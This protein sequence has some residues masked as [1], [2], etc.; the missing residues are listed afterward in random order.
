MPAF[1]AVRVGFDPTKRKSLGTA[2]PTCY[3]GVMQNCYTFIDFV[4]DDFNGDWRCM[5]DSF[6]SYTR[7]V[8]DDFDGDYPSS[9][10]NQ[11]AAGW[12]AAT[13]DAADIRYEDSGPG[14]GL[15]G[16]SK[17]QIMRSK[18][19]KTAS[20]AREFTDLVEGREY[21]LSVWMT[22]RL[23]DLAIDSPSATS[24]LAFG[25]D[26]TG[27][28]LDH[29][30]GSIVWFPG[31]DE[32]CSGASCSTVWKQY[33]GGFTAT[34]TGVVSL[35]V[36]AVSCDAA[37]I[38][39][40]VDDFYITDLA[41][42]LWEAA[43]KSNGMFNSAKAR[44]LIGEGYRGDVAT[45][46]PTGPPTSTPTLTDTPIGGE[47]PTHTP[48][49]TPKSKSL[50]LYYVPG[51]VEETPTPTQQGGSAPSPTQTPTWI[52]ADR[53]F[54]IQR[55]FDKESGDWAH[56]NV[57]ISARVK[58]ATTADVGR[59]RLGW[60]IPTPYE[61]P[62]LGDAVWVTP[63]ITPAE[64]GWSKVIGRID[65]W[66]AENEALQ[67]TLYIGLDV[68]D[69]TAAVG[70][71]VDD[72][73]VFNDVP[74]N[75]ANYEI[76]NLG[77]MDHYNYLVADK[78]VKYK[79]DHSYEG[80]LLFNDE[81]GNGGGSRYY[82]RFY[83]S[84]QSG[85]VKLPS[86]ADSF[87]ADGTGEEWGE[88]SIIRE[89]MAVKKKNEKAYECLG[90]GEYLPPAHIPDPSPASFV[91]ESRFLP[92]FV[93]EM[94]NWTDGLMINNP[95]GIMPMHS[96]E[97]SDETD[98][99]KGASSR[100]IPVVTNGKYVHL[101][102][103]WSENAS[104]T[105]PSEIGLLSDFFE[106]AQFLTI[107]AKVDGATPRQMFMGVALL[108]SA[109][110]S[111]DESYWENHYQVCL[112]DAEEGGIVIDYKD[113]R[114]PDAIDPVKAVTATLTFNDE[115]VTDW[116]MVYPD[117]WPTPVEDQQHIG[118]KYTVTVPRYGCIVTRF[119]TRKKIQWR[120]EE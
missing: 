72:V 75:D 18:N 26:L 19:A 80:D 14:K 32:L 76:A 16:S 119:V 114:L 101:G 64:D 96:N 38:G 112:A 100:F 82:Q 22:A 45:S 120:A 51:A 20:I 107:D 37:G 106:D 9:P 89:Y 91:E 23:F 27:Q 103:A 97:W 52:P 109:A 95:S 33:T 50:H 118:E 3:R 94:E 59:L 11:V 99:E 15:G 66:E 8:G 74:D 68:G 12:V 25:Y 67:M 39:L 42:H 2:Q 58:G 105:E 115:Y 92:R 86:N 111:Q 21:G 78:R 4:G 54:G 34:E 29:E 1:A 116:F 87:G 35:W 71:R 108:K 13:T 65:D 83:R 46:T 47:N 102:D 84:L 110:W 43:E 61:T 6:G 117:P 7:M 28:I 73:F 69:A 90:H 31:P 41:P 79:D 104:M 48:T 36:K 62:D 24:E 63:T 49:W 113:E 17:A 44:C 77:N 56:P 53:I 70:M 40:Y 10:P 98:G 60:A 30:A 55:T 5:K 85:D 57:Y 88:R 93:H 81:I